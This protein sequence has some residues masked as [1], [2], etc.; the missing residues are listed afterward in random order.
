MGTLDLTATNRPQLLVVPPL[1]VDFHN[2]VLPWYSERET[3]S[4]STGTTSD[5]TARSQLSSG[6]D[7]IG[8]IDINVNCPRQPIEHYERLLCQEAAL[9]KPL[10]PRNRAIRSLW[11][12]GS[13]LRQFSPETMTE[14]IFRLNNHFPDDNA[15][16]TLR[17]IEL[18]PSVFSDECLALLSGLGFNCIKL[19]ID[20][21]IASNDRSLSKL[22]NIFSHLADFNNLSMECQILFGGDSHPQFINR[23]L[24]YLS[25]KGSGCDRITLAHPDRLSPQSL[26]ERETSAH[27]LSNTITEMS[28]RRWLTLGNN[29]FVPENH[30]LNAE[31]ARGNLQLTPWGFQRRQTQFWLG[32]GVGGL[33]Y[34]RNTYYRTATTIE[35]YTQSINDQ[36][37]APKTL[38]RQPPKLIPAFSLVQELICHHRVSIATARQFEETSSLIEAGWLNSNGDTHYDL[39]PKGIENLYSIHSLFY[40]KTLQRN[41][42]TQS[43]SLNGQ[44]DD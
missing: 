35:Q 13:P 29:Q 43:E 34:F 14:L 42:N 26:D 12:R 36:R 11:L 31:Q 25:A 44:I 8:S 23:L 20:A 38:F 16:R 30:I 10:L 33:G 6:P 1:P 7:S 18:S 22:D 40:T 21:T 27:L 19:V 2:V 4:Y 15:N 5:P 41:Y 39:T 17:G 24:D 37:L 32:L 9:T 28:A 3:I